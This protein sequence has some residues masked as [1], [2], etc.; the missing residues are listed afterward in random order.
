MGPGVHLHRVAQL[1]G[2][3]LAPPPGALPT[4]ALGSGCVAWRTGW[5]AVQGK[6][7]VAVKGK[8]GAAAYSTGGAGRSAGG[9]LSVH[10][11]ESGA[12]PAPRSL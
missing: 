8:G 10:G 11:R 6:G 7:G 3:V 4:A 9:V 2:L 1:K 12:S 5:A